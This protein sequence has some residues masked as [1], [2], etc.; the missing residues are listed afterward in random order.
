MTKADRERLFAVDGLHNDF[1]FEVGG[2]IDRA[3]VVAAQKTRR[4]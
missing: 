1:N 4:G 3:F 2:L